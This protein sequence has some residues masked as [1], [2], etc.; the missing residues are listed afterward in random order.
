VVITHAHLDHS[1]YLPLLA[2]DGFTGPVICSEHTAA[3]LPIVM[4]DAAHLQEDEAR[5]SRESG[6]SR[7]T[8]PRPLFDTADAE[9][10]LGQLC[11]RPFHHHIAV[12]GAAMELSRAGHI[13]G[14]SW[15]TLTVGGRFSGC[16]QW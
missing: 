4:R 3:L 15:V 5:W 9:R 12:P 7:H 6:L 10:V 8:E 13:L 11:P 14:S 16:V 2:R 1:G